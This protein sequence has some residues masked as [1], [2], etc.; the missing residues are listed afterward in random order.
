MQCRCFRCSFPMRAGVDL[1][2]LYI[3]NAFGL[4]IPLLAFDF[5]FGGAKVK[6]ESIGSQGSPVFCMMLALGRWGPGMRGEVCG[7]HG[8]HGHPPDVQ[9]DED[10]E[11]DL[12]EFSK[13]CLCLPS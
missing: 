4:S 12:A 6:E 11:A 13:L 5:G 9:G 2:L 7:G 1:S 10:Q 3:L 8:P